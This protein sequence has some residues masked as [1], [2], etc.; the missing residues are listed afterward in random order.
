MKRMSSNLKTPAF[1]KLKM[2]QAVEI[3][4]KNK[5][6][7][8]LS[9]ML[10]HVKFNIKKTDDD[11]DTM[12]SQIMLTHKSGSMI[13][14]NLLNKMIRR[15]RF[16]ILLSKIN[17]IRTWI[18]STRKESVVKATCLQQHDRVRFILGSI[19]SI[20]QSKS[21]CNTSTQCSALRGLREIKFDLEVYL[22]FSTAF[23]KNIEKSENDVITFARILKSDIAISE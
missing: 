10:S 1:K 21:F 20:S 3:I 19:G 7:Y 2:F 18:L 12:L 14:S 22:R 4:E 23:K 6:L 8:G 15:R 9:E 17:E 5:C 16:I 13:R 11:I